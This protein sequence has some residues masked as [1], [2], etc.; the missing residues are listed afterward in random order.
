[1]HAIHVVVLCVFSFLTIANAKA[2]NP[3]RTINDSLVQ[4]LECRNLSVNNIYR[5]IRDDAFDVSRNMPVKNWGFKSGLARIAGCWSLSRT[6]RMMAYLARYNTSSEQRIEERVATVLDMIRGSTLVAGSIFSN[7]EKYQLEED[8]DLYLNES[9]PEA[10]ETSDRQET[11]LNL[12]QYP[13]QTNSLKNYCEKKLKNYKVFEVED[14]S[15]SNSKAGTSSNFWKALQVGYPQYFGPTVIQRNF[16]EEIEAQQEH[17]F[18]RI[19]NMKM[20]WE[21]GDRSKERNKKTAELLMKNLDGKRLTLLNLR[22]DRMRQH[23][24]MAKSYKKVLPEFFEIKVYD[25]NAPQVDSVIF[26]DRKQK[27]FFSPDILTRIKDPEPYHH[28]GVFIV[29]EQDRTL[30]ESAMLNYYHDLCM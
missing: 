10:A 16:R 18:Y 27:S 25:S 22:I 13:I 29:E 7:D 23:V 4:N 30:F 8:K 1:M 3:S 6:Q 20:I 12:D 24:V 15:F 17:L 28:L 21:N 14:S 19:R 9:Q 2:A 26:Y 11:V 5:A